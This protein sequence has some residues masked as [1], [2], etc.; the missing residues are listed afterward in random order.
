MSNRIEQLCL[1]S[2]SPLE[3]NEKRNFISYNPKNKQFENITVEKHT[4]KI[5]TGII[6]EGRYSIPRIDENITIQ[7]S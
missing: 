7:I 4:A 2:F 3:K 1:E 5:Q 6:K